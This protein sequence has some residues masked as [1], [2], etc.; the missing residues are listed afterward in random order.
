MLTLAVFAASLTTIVVSSLVVA[1]R[2]DKRHH[3]KDLSPL[4]KERI[5]LEQHFKSAPYQDEREGIRRRLAA[6]TKELEESERR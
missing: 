1:D 3:E 6:I 4:E 5:L 2:I